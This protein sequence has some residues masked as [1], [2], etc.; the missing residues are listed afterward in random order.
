MTG[1]LIILEDIIYP[2]ADE[3]SLTLEPPHTLIKSP[4]TPLMGGNSVLDSL[5]LVSLIVAVEGRIAERMNCSLTLANEKALS[6]KHSP[7]KTMQSL[8]DYILEL[9]NEEHRVKN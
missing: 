5:A 3:I 1:S 9:L 8:A 7:F 4:T 2:V 6:R